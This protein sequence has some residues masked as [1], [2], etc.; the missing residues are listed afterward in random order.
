MQGP[1]DH[2]VRS[3]VFKVAMTTAQIGVQRVRRRE[4][5]PLYD[6]IDGC[7]Q[8]S[9]QLPRKDSR[10]C[11]LRRAYFYAHAYMHPARSLL[12]AI[13]L[14]EVLEMLIGLC[15]YVCRARSVAA[16]LYAFRRQAAFFH[17]L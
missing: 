7:K 4:L 14:A 1:Y 10:H 8:R 11:G 2:L 12:L 6:E 16:G 9:R 3:L 17:L 15:M 13:H 5:C